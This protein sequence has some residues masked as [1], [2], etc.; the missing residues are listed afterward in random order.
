MI[1]MIEPPVGKLEKLAD[2][3][4]DPV[5]GDEH[6]HVDAAQEIEGLVAGARGVGGV[7]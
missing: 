3:D 1:Q 7:D 4:E 5:Q 6:E 2:G